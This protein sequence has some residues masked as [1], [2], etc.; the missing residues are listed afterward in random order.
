MVEGLYAFSGDARAR[1]FKFLAFTYESGRVARVRIRWEL[2]HGAVAGHLLK[3]SGGT[4]F[5]LGEVSVALVIVR[6]EPEMLSAVS[7]VISVCCQSGDVK[8]AL[9]DRGALM[10]LSECT[11][12]LRV[13][14][15]AGASQ[16]SV[17]R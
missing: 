13:G 8:G 14:R 15:R 16:G 9:L 6:H 7:A 12:P 1:A 11:P 3:G 10:H 5:G 4:L 17:R 2:T